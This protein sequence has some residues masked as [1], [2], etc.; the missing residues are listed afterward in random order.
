MGK[1]SFALQVNGRTIM[2]LDRDHQEF[3]FEV[4]PEV[5]SK[6]RVATVYWSFVA[7]DRLDDDELPGL[8]LEAWSQVVPKKISRPVLEAAKGG[9]GG[10]EVANS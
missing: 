9:A 4:R 7:L 10:D 6:C 1:K 2:K 5:F 8:V 3:L